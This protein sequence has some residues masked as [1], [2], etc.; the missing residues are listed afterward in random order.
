MN[1]AYKELFHCFV[2]NR[3]G[4]DPDDHEHD[5]ALACDWGFICNEPECGWRTDQRPCPIHA[6]ITFSGLRLVECT[7]EPRHY[8]FAHDRDDYGHGCPAC[9][10][11]YLFKR[12]SELEVC[13]HKVWRRWRVT[14]LLVELGF[15]VRLIRSH[16]S[17]WTRG[18]ERCLVEVRWV[19]SR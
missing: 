8:L 9:Y 6:P 19:W 7:A 14:R 18:C 2:P 3:Q 17:S 16:Q 13:R 1:A 15:T 4:E 11:R 5:P 12:L 10:G